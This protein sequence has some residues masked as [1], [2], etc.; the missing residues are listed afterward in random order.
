MSAVITL[1]SLIPIDEKLT[2]VIP[3]ELVTV[4]SVEVE[5]GIVKTKSSVVEEPPKVKAAVVP[6]SAT[7][8]I[9]L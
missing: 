5:A 6:A 9:E 3:D 7:P 1:V 8:V 2:E 4:A